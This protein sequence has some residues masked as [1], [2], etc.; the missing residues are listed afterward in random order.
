[1]SVAAF[2]F[3]YHLRIIHHTTVMDGV[4]AIKFESTFWMDE[5]GHG[6]YLLSIHEMLLLSSCYGLRLFRRL[7]EIACG[8]RSWMDRMQDSSYTPALGKLRRIPALN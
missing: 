7:F 1:M 3:K 6:D 4:M 8:R 5:M 2:I